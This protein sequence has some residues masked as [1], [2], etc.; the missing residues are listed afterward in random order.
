MRRTSCIAALFV[1]SLASR[2]FAGGAHDEMAAALIAQADLSPGPGA[3]PIGAAL[4]P[5]G[6]QASAGV[7]MAKAHA[8]ADAHRAGAGAAAA[9]L[10]HQGPGSAAALA[11]AA[12]A[13]S[14]AAA[15]QA[16]AARAK[17]RASH[18]HGKP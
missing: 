14:E 13:A 8:Q 15:G 9:H 1:I 18:H 4:T 11:H 17:D 2:A 3:L 16:Q 12:Q 6:K 10:A 5:A 7:D